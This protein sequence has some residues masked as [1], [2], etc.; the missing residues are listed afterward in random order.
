MREIN[1]QINAA[2][3]KFAVVVS[4]FNSFFTEQL[5]KGAVDCFVRHGGSDL[6]LT[7]VRVPG[8][9]ETPIIASNTMMTT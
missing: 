3:M 2:G 9:N 4:R 6:D 8:A 1:G 5:L 7:V